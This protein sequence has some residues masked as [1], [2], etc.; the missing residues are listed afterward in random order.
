MKT[1]IYKLFI[2]YFF[3]V[4]RVS[5]VINTFQIE[6]MQNFLPVGS[7]IRA[8]NGIHPFEEIYAQNMEIKGE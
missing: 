3:I 7:N 5:S 1:I 8:Q 4:A 6:Q 2:L